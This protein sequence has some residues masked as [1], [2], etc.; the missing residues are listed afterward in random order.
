[1]PVEKTLSGIQYDDLSLAEL[2]SSTDGL[3]AQVFE[4]GFRS[5]LTKVL[6]FCNSFHV[7]YMII[8]KHEI[9][10]SS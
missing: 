10:R 3:L 9:P 2:I 5:L 8:L 7:H 1:M 6:N 4:S